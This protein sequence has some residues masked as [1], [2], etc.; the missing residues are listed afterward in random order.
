MEGCDAS[1]GVS[2]AVVVVA[3]VELIRLRRGVVSVAMLSEMV[4]D[5]VMFSERRTGLLEGLV[6]V[7]CADALPGADGEGVVCD[8]AR[9]AV[10]AGW[11]ADFATGWAA[12][13][14]GFLLAAAVD[15][16]TRGFRF[17]SGAWLGAGAVSSSVMRDSLRRWAVVRSVGDPLLLAALDEGSDVAGVDSIIRDAELADSL[18]A[19]ALADGAL[20]L[21]I[22]TALALDGVSPVSLRRNWDKLVSRRGVDC[23]CGWSRRTT[24]E[25]ALRVAL[26]T[27]SGAGVCSVEV[28][29]R[30]SGSFGSSTAR[31]LTCSQ[32]GST[33]G[34]ETSITSA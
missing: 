28:A 34:R 32:I 9:V 22:S 8:S 27:L 21:A 6:G 26:S 11:G 10:L 14:G 16:A 23:C 17:R 15:S 18:A 12:T 30:D 3:V 31:W 20:L 1:E 5:G 24:C 4:G 7:F 29:T 25:S 13:G 33:F 19:A 2:A